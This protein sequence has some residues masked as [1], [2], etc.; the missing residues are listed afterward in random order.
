LLT[1]GSSGTPKWAAFTLNQLFE[2]AKTVALALDAKPHDRWLLSLPLHHVG[3]LG[4]LLRALWSGGTIVLENKE[5]PHP[6][7]LQAAQA[8]FASLVPTQLYRLIQ[9]DFQPLSTQLIIGG[10]PLARHIYE[11]GIERDYQLLLTYGLTEMG[12]T[13]FL[14]SRPIWEQHIPYLGHPLPGRKVKILEQELLVSGPSLFA[15]YGREPCRPGGDWF[16]TGDLGIFHQ[17]HGFAIR[18]RK[19]FQFISG[20]ENIQPEE[21]ESALL[22]SGLIEQAIVV[23]LYD[24]EFGARPIAFVKTSAPD[25]QIM[26]ALEPLLPKY[27]I[28]IAFAPYPE[29]EN[30]KPNRRALIRL[31]NKK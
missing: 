7:R 3:G 30:L 21:I 28:P 27:K 1:S 13:I 12:S 8:R 23:P 5:L 9:S 10:A 17:Q 26:G 11:K 2:S 22:S 6:A 24:E 29:S 25:H 19:D 16:S 20:G 18:G 31:A 14:T 15:G 4:V